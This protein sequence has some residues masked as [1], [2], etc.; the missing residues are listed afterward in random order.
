[1]TSSPIVCTTVTEFQDVL[2]EKLSNAAEPTL[3]FIPTMGALH[4]GHQELFKTARANNAVVAISVFVNPLQF[5]RAEDFENYPRNL[6]ADV[7]IAAEVGVDVIFAPELQEMYPDETPRISVRTGHMGEVL[8]GALRPGHFDG[9]GTVV[10]KLF[11]IVAAGAAEVR[12]VLPF[13]AY[14][15]QK[16]AQQLAILSAMVEDFN[17]PVQIHPVPIVRD[18]GGLALSSRNQRLNEDQL[19]QARAL[20]EGL[21]LLAAEAAAGRPLDVAAAI[22]HITAS[23]VSAPG[24]DVVDELVIVDADTFTPLTEEQ[25]ADPTSW[26]P[27]LL[28]LLAA[29]VG[30]VRL[31]DNKILKG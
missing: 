23:V 30:P 11:N 27:R 12:G 17:L 21:E 15:G 16:D 6:D 5:D 28:A 18:E 9:V 24:D 1:M 19:I 14:F 26:P 13:T 8:E 3:G 22:D 4:A 20:N 31:I 25:R 29:F 10:N 7:A 2:A